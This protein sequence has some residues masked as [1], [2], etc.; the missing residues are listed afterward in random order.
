MLKTFPMPENVSQLKMFLPARLH[1]ASKGVMSQK[2][3]R[4]QTAELGGDY[5]LSFRIRSVP[6][7]KTME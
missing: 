6:R 5:D 3:D 4:T 1:N 2:L 7:S